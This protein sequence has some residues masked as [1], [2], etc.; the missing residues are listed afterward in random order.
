MAGDDRPERGSRDDDFHYYGPFGTPEGGPGSSPASAGG[1][2]GS[3]PGGQAST[4]GQAA[5][6]QG[7]GSEQPLGQSP[8]SAQTFGGTPAPGSGQHSRG[9]QDFGRT[10]SSGGSQ[11]FGAPR[12]FGGPQSG[13]SPDFS[14]GRNPGGSQDFAGPRDSGGSP[15]SGDRQNFG[16][17]PNLGGAQPFGGP[18]GPRST[19]GPGP[20]GQAGG[21]G[22]GGQGGQ[23]A[24][25]L[26][27]GAGGPGS[28]SVPSQGL[29]GQPPHGTSSPG[30]AAAP[31]PFAAPG[32]TGVP[33]GPP[34]EPRRSQDHQPTQPIPGVGPGYRSAE[35]TQLFPAPGNVPPLQPGPVFPP[36]PPQAQPGR[37]RRRGG[38]IGVL[39]LAVIIAAL[40]GGLAGYGGGLL[41]PRAGTQAT[42]VGGPPPTTREPLPPAPPEANTVEVAKRVLPSTVMIR[43]GSTG[44]SGFIL[45]GEGRIMTNNH[46]VEKAANG[47]RITVVY[48]DGSRATARILGRSPTYD[49]AVIQVPT[50]E[51]LV[52]M[53]IGDSDAVK[54]GEAAIAI[55]SPLGLANTVT[56]GIISSK[57][58]PV[59]VGD[60]SDPG[61]NTAYINALQTDAPINPGNS[62]GPL[63]DAGGR[64]IGVNS[65]ILTIGSAQGQAG[66][67]GLGFAIPI[68]QAMDIGEMLIKD[69]KATY[70]VIGANVSDAPD[71]TGVELSGVESG[72]PA[73]TAG[74]A[75][76]DV[77]TSI[78]GK[79]VTGLEQLIVA[80]R[81]HRPGDQIVLAYE[82]GGKKAEAKVTLGAREG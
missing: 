6:G 72:G 34:P 4:G 25:R 59:V 30:S 27:P 43:V 22:F 31:H 56:Q 74:L 62:G 50:S 80:I 68:N 46:V 79:P 75:D 5:G 45:D 47:G 63:V 14:G 21:P 11:D 7:S 13:G 73:D 69:G 55:G 40:V 51:K 41:V 70:P 39:L 23:E 1:P 15:N 44:G 67:I 77:V 9:S 32:P 64:V 53:E 49:L 12:N 57:D 33:A 19:P 28:A 42:P 61:A 3:G 35:P 26:G 16:G 17:S 2:G 66:S 8:G 24:G 78:D 81:T 10:A 65:A 38:G 58:R 18:Q 60:D 36:P 54:V 76:G 20:Q 52:P 37:Q 29:G 71:G 48:N 82:R